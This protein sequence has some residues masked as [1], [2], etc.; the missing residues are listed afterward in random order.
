MISIHHQCD[1]IQTKQS[2]NCYRFL[3]DRL[4]VLADAPMAW[5]AAPLLRLG[6]FEGTVRLRCGRL[7]VSPMLGSCWTLASTAGAC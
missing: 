1:I 3:L 5:R 2:R 7:L 4:R 6:A